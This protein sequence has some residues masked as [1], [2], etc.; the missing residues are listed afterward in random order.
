M[1]AS[2]SGMKAG[3]SHMGRGYFRVFFF[4]NEGKAITHILKVF[5]T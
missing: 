4:V 3:R 1:M 5:I 2:R